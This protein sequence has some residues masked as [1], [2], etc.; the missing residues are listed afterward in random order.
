MIFKFIFEQN[1]LKRLRLFLLLRLSMNRYL[2][3][4]HLRPW[5]IRKAGIKLGAHAHIGANVTFDNWSADLYDIGDFCTI[6]MN[7]VLLTHG[8]V[9]QKDNTYR[10]TVGKLII[11]KHVFIGAGTIITRPVIIGDNVMIGAGSIV[12]KDIPS[13]C[14]VAGN[15]AKIIRY[16]GGHKVNINIRLVA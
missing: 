9:R 11:G 6:T 3:S 5:I 2:E 4:K 10:S 14:V 1:H 15:P 8:M 16:W 12:T 13:N 7:T